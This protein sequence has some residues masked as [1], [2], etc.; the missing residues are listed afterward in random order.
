MFLCFSTLPPSSPPA[1]TEAFAQSFLTD[2]EWWQAFC[3]EIAQIATGVG[4]ES[5]G[6]NQLSEAGGSA[7]FSFTKDGLGAN[8]HGM[9]REVSFTFA[10]G[11]WRAD[12]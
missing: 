9:F 10:E 3:G 2:P 8:G 6:G 11:E 1:D 7:V 4:V 5:I 12:G